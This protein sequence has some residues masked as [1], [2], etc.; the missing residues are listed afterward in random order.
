MRL[1][2]F[3]PPGAG[4]GTQAAA[5]KAKYG[6]L[7]IST[8]EMLREA[9]AQGSP[10]GVKTKAIVDSGSLVPDEV[11]GELVAERL[12]RPDARKGFLLDGYPRTLRQAEILEVVLK[13]RKE[14]LDAVVKVNLSDDEVVKR[15]S[16]RR[17][18]T[19]CKTN[20][21]VVFS[22]PK[23]AGVCDACGGALAQREDDRED[24][25]RKRLVV[26]G[27]QTAPLA[28][29]YAKKGL[30]REVDGSGPIDEVEKRMFKVL[31]AA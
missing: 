12:S 26:Y 8:G 21:H 6:I 16:G 20:Y 10:V 23:R 13:A 1:V 4:K 18:C 15:L 29:W 27:Q 25:I 9:I 3:G 22:A 2:L 11:V 28:A 31:E 7:H 17:T 14:A 30:L 24:V 5:I 19:S